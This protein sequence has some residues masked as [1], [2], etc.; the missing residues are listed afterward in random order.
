MRATG[1]VAT[2]ALAAATWMVWEHA[3]DALAIVGLDDLD[4]PGRVAAVFLF[5]SIV[6]AA[7]GRLWPERKQT[8]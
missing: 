5:L 1:A 6:E 8:D 3:P 4:I 7:V 2:L